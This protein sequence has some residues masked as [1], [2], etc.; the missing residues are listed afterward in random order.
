MA[1]FQDQIA[2]AVD[3]PVFLSSLLQVP[4]IHRITGKRVGVISADKTQLTPEHLSKSG[5]ADDMPIAV[6]GME[7][8]EPFR[9]AIFF[10]D[11]TLDD[12]AVRAG[13]VSV[14]TELRAQHADLGAILL[15]CSDL[16][17][18]AA[19]VQRAT[20]LPVFGFIT[21]INYDHQTLVRRPF[22]GNL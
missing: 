14:A 1:L 5:I 13:V 8:C 11:G 3:V 4:F 9:Q 12:D 16:P 10:P 20:G 6:G 19:D 2:A 7:T 18:Y 15:E 21:M 22:V 17:P